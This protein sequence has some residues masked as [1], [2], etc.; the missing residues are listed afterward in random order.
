MVTYRE[1]VNGLRSLGLDSSRPVIVHTS[2]SAFGEVH[3]GVDTLLGALLSVFPRLMAPTHTY[4]TMLIPG[5][6][7]AIT[8]W[9]TAAGIRLT[10][11]PRCSTPICPPTA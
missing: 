3:G 7:Q 9:F 10:P 1:L 8:A 4:K 5:T 2:L 6:A 11:W